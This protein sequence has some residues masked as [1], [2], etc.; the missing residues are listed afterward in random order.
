MAES[1][2]SRPSSAGDT[3]GTTT[4]TVRCTGDV[5]EAVGTHECEFAFEGSTLRDCLD[6]FFEVHPDVEALVMARAP[7][8]AATSGWAPTAG[9]P[10][11]TWR[12]NDPDDRPRTYARVT[13]DGRFN[14]HLGGLDAELDDG[15]R[16]GLLYPFIF[17]C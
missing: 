15:A 11:G 3:K 16:V 8:D 14:E 4:V 2:R 7:E 13:I 9:P 1:T 6:A 5:R 17:C 10:P 12:A